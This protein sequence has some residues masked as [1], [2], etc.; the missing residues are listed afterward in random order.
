MIRSIQSIRIVRHTAKYDAMLSFYQDGLDMRPI[1]Q[2][3]RAPDDRGALLVFNGPTSTTSV[4]V[5]TLPGP[6][7]VSDAT[8]DEPPEAPDIATHHPEGISLSVEVANVGAQ[9]E[10][11]QERGVAI[12][13]E[14]TNMPWGHRSFSVGDP[15]GLQISFFQD[16]NRSEN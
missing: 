11:V 2:W 12:T 3:D 10:A 6:G 15:D 14:I 9:Y 8:V 13:R 4:E 5:L 1:G 7:P 16:M